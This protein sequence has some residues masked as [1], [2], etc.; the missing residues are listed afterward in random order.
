MN[1]R[2]HAK[3]IPTIGIQIQ[4]SWQQISAPFRQV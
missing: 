2:L 4:M 1:I 3:A